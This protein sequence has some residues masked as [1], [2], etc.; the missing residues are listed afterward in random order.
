[1]ILA[2]ILF[3]VNL[4]SHVL[5]IDPQLSAKA[6]AIIKNSINLLTTKQI[7]QLPFVKNYQCIK[8]K[9]DNYFIKLSAY[10]P[11]CFIQIIDQEPKV[12]TS[13]SRI[14]SADFYSQ[15]CLNNLP[16]INARQDDN[17]FNLLANWPAFCFT[18]YQIDWQAAEKILLKGHS[19]LLIISTINKP[20]TKEIE[21]IIYDLQL[22]NK[23]PDKAVLDIR[24][25]DQIILKGGMVN[26]KSF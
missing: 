21:K 19:G 25:A 14:V 20:I 2:I 9:D 12:C 18:D 11:I 13:G 22:K 1:M 4:N 6:K 17:K 7:E 10:A 16:V 26:G 23:I 5:I 3:I 24:F 15:E 8:I